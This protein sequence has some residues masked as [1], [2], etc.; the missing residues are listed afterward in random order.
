MLLKCETYCLL[1]IGGVGMSSIGKYLKLRG[2]EVYGYDREESVM[3]KSLE[4]IGVKILYDDSK[5][6]FNPK[7]RSSKT[8]I[9]YSS[10]IPE[11]NRMLKFYRENGNIIKKRALFLSEICNHF[12]TIA[13]AGTHGKTTTSAILS[14][15]FISDNK[16]ITAFIGGVLNNYESNLIIKGNDFFIVEADE[17]DRSFLY[18]KPEY[19]C[20]TSIDKDHFDIYE[21][22]NDLLES[23]RKFSELIKNK[24]VVESKVPFNGLK[25]GLNSN[26]DYKISNIEPSEKGFIFDLKTPT[27]KFKSVFFNQIGSH[28]LSNAL[29]AI[30]L[31]D[32]VGLNM[33]K[34]LGS[35]SSFSGVKRRMEII[36]FKSKFII[37]DYAHHPTEIKS[38]FETIQSNYFKK[39]NCVIFQPHLYSRTKYL[40]NEFAS[41]LSRFDN[42]FLLDIYAARERKIKGIS[43]NLLLKKIK[44]SSKELIQKNQI[45]EKIINSKAKVFAILGAGDIGLEVKK[46]LL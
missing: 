9:I 32:Q 36:N 8:L 17:F 12:I 22:E 3:T 45:K 10:A 19:G 2:N 46:I 5:Y 40:I 43:S 20:I 27:N 23:F 6:L 44:N 21:S 14:H 16:K 33:K 26:S 30:T 37:D 15:M 25:Y 11:S 39:E 34:V 31:A 18:L 42:V 29:C 24:T 35:L 38:I 1:G 7:L 28:N 13:V 41:E 4:K